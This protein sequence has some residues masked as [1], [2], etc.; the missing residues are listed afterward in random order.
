MQSRTTATRLLTAA[1]LSAAT[2]GSV[3]GVAGPASAAGNVTVTL[4]LEVS[5]TGPYSSSPIN[6]VNL[7]TY[8]SAGAQID[9]FC[10]L[11][12][13]P[14]SSA[15]GRRTITP[16]GGLAV[17][18]PAGGSIEGRA[19]SHNCWNQMWDAPTTYRAGAADATVSWYL[20]P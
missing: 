17:S 15:T 13:D 11:Q 10:V 20:H 2:V 18:V 14:D 1:A 4:H 12:G 9:G 3:L 5:G 16:A 7:R 19:S 8:N 6:S